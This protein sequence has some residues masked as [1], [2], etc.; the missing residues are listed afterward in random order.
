MKPF[1]DKCN[2]QGIKYSSVKDAWKKIEKNDLTIVH[3]ILY[4]KKEKIYP[5]CLSK[6]NIKHEKQMI[7]LMIAISN[8]AGFHYIAVEILSALLR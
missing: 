4:A 5:T 8:R 6:H 3:N 1:I 2:Q 7:L